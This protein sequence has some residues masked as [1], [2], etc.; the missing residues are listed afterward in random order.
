M[1]AWTKNCGRDFVSNSWGRTFWGSNADK[2]EIEDALASLQ[3]RFNAP[4]LMGEW[5]FTALSIEKGAAWNFFDFF[6]R[7]AAV[8]TPALSL[9]LSIPPSK[10][11]SPE[12][13]F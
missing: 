1:S 2:K 4:V 6:V 12:L 13:T 5:G 8:W 11:A 9:S 10:L 3:T 7:T